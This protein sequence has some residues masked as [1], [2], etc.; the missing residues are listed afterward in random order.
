MLLGLLE[1]F[2]LLYELL[3]LLVAEGFT[4]PLLALLTL[5]RLAR[6]RCVVLTKARLHLVCVFH[7]FEGLSL[8]Q[9]EDLFKFAFCPFF[10]TRL[11]HSVLKL[12]QFLETHSLAGSLLHFPSVSLLNFELL[13]K[14]IFYFYQRRPKFNNHNILSP[15]MLR[16]QLIHRP[17][18]QMSKRIFFQPH[19]SYNRS[20][21]VAQDFSLD[22]NY[23]LVDGLGQLLGF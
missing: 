23:G 18:V 16:W 11:H 19:I 17:R 9:P 2:C 22:G 1:G 15:L 20:F 21:L 13:I 3:F 10:C 6:G 12:V 8:K 5:A 14:H 7:A 4:Q